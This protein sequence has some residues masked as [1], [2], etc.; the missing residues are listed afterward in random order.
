MSTGRGSTPFGVAPWC[1]EPMKSSQQPRETAPFANTIGIAGP[2]ISY[3]RRS[4]ASGQPRPTL[5]NPVSAIC[6][7]AATPVTRVA[8]A[9]M[10][11]FRR[12]LCI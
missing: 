9:Q 3:S 2:V 8:A 6:W 1:A 5:L 12:L 4:A 10:A 7:P 11:A